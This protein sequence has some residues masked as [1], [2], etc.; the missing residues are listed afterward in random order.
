[1][2]IPVN[3]DSE[4]I[5]LYERLNEY[6]YNLF[7]PNNSFYNDICISYNSENNKDIILNDRKNLIYMK[8]GNKMLCQLECVLK[9]YNSENKKAICQC[10]AQID[11]EEP[12]LSEDKMIFTKNVIA[13]GF[14]KTIKNS[15]FLVLKCYKLVFDAN[16]IG[17]NI[18]MI[19]MTIILLISIM[20]IIFHYIQ[21]QKKIEEFIESII[22]IK[23]FEKKI[24]AKAL[25]KN[26][27]NE[28]NIDKRV[29]TFITVI[30]L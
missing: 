6:G 2:N 10:S 24:K 14:L 29:G 7:D 21:D 12:D 1:M 4:T 18:G 13:E 5:T 23:Y 26:K 22:K 11:G 30:F 19:I 25:Q 27:E 8:N 16:N 28:K 3:L 15:N 9:A 20:F 17:K